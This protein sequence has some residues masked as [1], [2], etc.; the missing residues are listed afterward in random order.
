MTAAESLMLSS[1]LL[2]LGS[3]M[4]FVVTLGRALCDWLDGDA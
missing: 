2:V 1:V 3:I 4:G